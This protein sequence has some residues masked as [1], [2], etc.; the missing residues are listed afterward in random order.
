MENQNS[1]IYELNALPDNSNHSSNNTT[2]MWTKLNKMTR[3]NKLNNFC[4]EFGET[5]G[6]DPVD[7]LE[8]KQYLK[9]CLDRKKLQSNKDVIYDKNSGVIESIPGL[10][11]NKKDASSVKHGKSTKRRFTLKTHSKSTMKLSSQIIMRSKTMKN[12]L[13]KNNDK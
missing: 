1:T 10:T 2:T 7:V 6:L 9:E 12:T 13:K 11:E 8:L 5:K 3:I 4:E